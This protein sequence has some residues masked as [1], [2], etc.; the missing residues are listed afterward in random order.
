MIRI[1]GSPKRLCDGITRRDWLMASSLSLGIS[2]NP[3]KAAAPAVRQRGFGAARNVILLYPF[4]GPSHIDTFDTKPD[5]PAEIRGSFKTIQS[6]LPGCN[7]SEYLPLTAG[8]MDRVTVLRSLTHPWNFHGMQWATTGLPAGSIPHEETQFRP[9]HWPFVGSVVHRLSQHK[10][11][12][13]PNNVMLPWMLSK[14][15]TKIPYARPHAAWLGSAYEPVWGEFAGE[16]TREVVRT[17]DGPA[18]SVRDPYLGITPSGRF[19]IAPNTELPSEMTLDRLNGRKSLLEQ[20]DANSRRAETRLAR[21]HEANQAHGFGLLQSPRVRTALDLGREPDRLRNAYGMTLFGQG[22]LQARRL[23]ESGCQF[24]T[25]IWD[26]FKQL[27]TGWDTHVDHVNRMKNELLPGFDSAFSSLVIDLE[28]RGMLADTLV[29]VLCE[30]GRTPRMEG[31]G[32]GHWGR[33][34]TN[35]MAGAGVA[36]GR[37]IGKTDKI[38]AEVIDRPLSA[39]DVLATTYHLCGFDPHTMLPDSQN[40]PVALLPYGEVIKEVLA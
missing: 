40:R 37:V 17:S 2:A 18:E 22:C 7:I 16:A 24:V 39:K 27:N 32:R 15:R 21:N 14:N 31:N 38:G 10:Q 5:A 29:L 4:G 3:L 19:S 12:G 35:L 23:V 11:S 8:I 13:I 28:D 1:L 25:V 34:Y 30:M 33:A 26:E 9:D 6:R 36:R 20:F